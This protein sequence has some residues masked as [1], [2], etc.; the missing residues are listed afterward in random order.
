MSTILFFTSDR[1]AFANISQTATTEK[2]LFVPD[3]VTGDRLFIGNSTMISYDARC[4]ISAFDGNLAALTIDTL[5]KRL[6]IGT[7]SPTAA[8]HIAHPSG[9]QI[10]G[11]ANI[12]GTTTLTG[13]TNVIGTMTATALYGSA[14]GLTS[15]PAAR[16]VGSLQASVYA[17]ATIPLTAISGYNDGVLGLSGAV[18]ADTLSITS[19]LSVNQ[20]STGYIASGQGDFAFLSS[21]SGSVSTFTVGTLYVGLISSATINSLSSAI[22]AISNLVANISTLLVNVSSSATNNATL[23]ATSTATGLNTVSITTVSN[24]LNSVSTNVTTV[25]TLLNGVSSVGATNTVNLTTVSNLLNSVSTN[26]TT[27]STNVNSLSNLVNGI[28]SSLI[29]V[30]NTVATT[31]T[32]LGTVSNSV[33]FLLT[34]N[35]LSSL[36]I[37]T[38][39]GFFSTLSAGTVYSKFV[40]DGSRLSNVPFIVPAYVSV[41]TL[42]SGSIIASSISSMYVTANVGIFSTLNSISAVIS[43]LFAGNL[44]TSAGSFSSLSAGTINVDI[45]NSRFLSTATGT[46]S[47]FTVG[48]LFAN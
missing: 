42:S 7:S 33:N 43:N 20:I 28:S 29:T 10:T 6:G 36:T 2:V 13:A 41:N 48:T 26:V 44:L 47:T 24:L 18:A 19:S 11:P 8:L 35:N 9:I 21:G 3:P 31:V 12:T 4:N 38:S 45:E 5:N 22:F 17:N 34:V 46:A 23:T 39:Y 32:N 25:S 16:L 37:S 30:S 14:M 15:I 1:L 40:G 27:V